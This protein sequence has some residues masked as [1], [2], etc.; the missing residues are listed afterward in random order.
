MSEPVTEYF[1]DRADVYARYR[2]R[3]AAAAID[4]LLDG[5]PPSAVVV[6]VGAGTGIA[7]RQLAAAGAEVVGVEPNGAMRAEAERAGGGPR[8][9]AGTAEATGLPDA[10]ARAA[11]CAQCFHWFDPARALPELHRL[12]VPGGRLALLYNVRQ[13]TTPFMKAYA[14][15]VAR[16]KE[17]TRAAGRRTPTFRADPTEGGWFERARTR[18][19]AND[20]RLSW[21]ELSGRL[22]SAS[23]L[24]QGPGRA[25][26]V[27]RLRE[28]FGRHADGAGRV[29]YAQATELTLADRA[30]R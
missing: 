14:E 20:E 1:G 18:S 5:L 26:L 6:D 29:R 13:A 27:T 12:L 24:P 9:R 28:A 15:I 4:A 22:Q 11:V 8:Y 23:Y 21:E 30:A 2:P 16:A 3:Y 10:C 25:E 19:F 7:S 17:L